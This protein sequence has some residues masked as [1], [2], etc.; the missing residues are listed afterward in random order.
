MQPE[1]LIAIHEGRLKTLTGNSV[2]GNDTQFR[3]VSLNYLLRDADN[4]ALDLGNSKAA[5]T[6]HK[7]ML[8]FMEVRA[9]DPGIDRALDKAHHLINKAFGYLR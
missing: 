2:T 9:N 6:F 4:A 3:L 8:A 1:Q 7:A 5:A